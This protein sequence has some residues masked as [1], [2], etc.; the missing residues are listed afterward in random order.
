MAVSLLE[1]PC[2]APSSEIAEPVGFHDA[3]LRV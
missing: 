3:T 1:V 2:Q